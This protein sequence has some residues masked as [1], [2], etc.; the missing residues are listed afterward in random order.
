M[1]G[2]LLIYATCLRWYVARYSG[3]VP[4]TPPAG[5]LRADDLMAVPGPVCSRSLTSDRRRSTALIHR[6]RPSAPRCLDGEAG[7]DQQHCKRGDV[8]GVDAVRIGKREQHL[9]A[10]E[11]FNDHQ[12]DRDDGQHKRHDL[13]RLG[14]V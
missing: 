1:G 8:A 2:L 4:A 9:A 3:P 5:R 13:R 14:S 7:R 12:P 10:G 11:R 6:W